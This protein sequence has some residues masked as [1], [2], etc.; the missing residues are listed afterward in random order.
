MSADEPRFEVPEGVT[1][2]GVLGEGGALSG[3]LPGYECRPQQLEMARAVEKALAQKRFLLAEA[4]TG[5]GKTLAYLVPALLSGKR[6]V[7]STAT[8]TLQE[9]IF[10]KDLPLL[11]DEVGLEVKAA[12]LKGRSNYLCAARFERFESFPLFPT[13]AEAEHWDTFREWA[14]QTQT[15]DRGETDVPDDWATWLQVSTTP[16]SCTGGKCPFYETCF[17][18]R[19]RRAAADCQLIIVNH[20]LFFADLSLKARGEAQELGVLPAYDAVIFDEAHALEDVATEYFGQTVSSGRLI[21]LVNDVLERTPKTHAHSATLTALAMELRGRTEQFFEKVQASLSLGERVRDAGGRDETQDARLLPHSLDDAAGEAQLVKETLGA[22]AALCPEED[23]DLGG[24]HRRA[25]ES[26]L[27][28]EVTLRADD[29]AQVYWASTRGRSVALRAA[30]ID[31][32]AS[33]AAALYDSVDSVVFTSATLQAGGGFDYVLARLGLEGRAT[34]TLRVDSPFDY[35]RQ[36]LLYVPGYLP[37]P[38]DPEWTVQFAREVFRLLALSG[39]RAFVLF[40]SYKH[41]EA[42]HALVAPHLKLPVLK[43][44][45]APRRALLSRFTEEP[46]VLFAT[47]SFWEGVDVPGAALSMVIIDRLPFA[48]PNEPLQAARMD[49]VREHG[50]NPFDEYQV[51]QAALALRQGFGRLIRTAR[52]FGVV[53]I[54]DSR[55]VTRRYGKRFLESLPRAPVTMHFE[56][57]RAFWQNAPHHHE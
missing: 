52:D 1:P 47:Q 15:G 16:D 18:T 20:A 13:P 55:L 46:S 57:V 26:A 29:P 56:E 32:G 37:P 43:Q 14:L 48:P 33:L 11:R 12:L 9:Q 17:V 10:L 24:L 50:G 51:P 25:L 22:M 40:T 53:A 7:V 4:G 34:D 8:R 38:A 19:A 23:A 36:A 2:D 6:V 39:G 45:E 49:A 54:G 30:P 42:V 3:A 21:A 28:L 41:M 27:A 5:T 44:G 31:V 35:P